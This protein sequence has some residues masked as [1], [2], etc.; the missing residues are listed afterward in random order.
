MERQA[1]AGV[2]FAVGGE[3]Q[4]G[5]AA[6]HLF[7]NELI[8]GDNTVLAVLNN[9]KL[10]FLNHSVINFVGTRDERFNAHMFDALQ[11]LIKRSTHL[12]ATGEKERVRFFNR[13]REKIRQAA[14]L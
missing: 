6:F 8:L 14:R 7:N 4:S 3:P 10:T 2:K 12:S 5:A 11:N 9:T 13:I 1:E